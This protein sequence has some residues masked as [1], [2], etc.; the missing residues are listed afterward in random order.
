[1]TVGW[2]YADIPIINITISNMYFLI[3]FILLYDRTKIRN[4]ASL[5]ERLYHNFLLN[6]T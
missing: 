5:K 4:K 1:M 6:S 2:L 3:L